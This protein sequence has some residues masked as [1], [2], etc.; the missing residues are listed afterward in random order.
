MDMT[1]L[2]ATMMT[3]TMVMTVVIAHYHSFAP[4]QKIQASNARIKIFM[5]IQFYRRNL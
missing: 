5:V 3:S 2:T 4:Y 1:I